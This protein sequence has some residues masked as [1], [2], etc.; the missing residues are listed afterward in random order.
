V[1]RRLTSLGSRVAGA[2]DEKIT[3][4]ARGRRQSD[5]IVSIDQDELNPGGC[6]VN[7]QAPRITTGDRDLP[8]GGE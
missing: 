5:R 3:P 4:F 6:Q 1:V 2:I 7:R 8:T